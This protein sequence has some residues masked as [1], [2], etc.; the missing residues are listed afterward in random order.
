MGDWDLSM[1]PHSCVAGMVPT[2]PSFR[3]CET[4]FLSLG[5]VSRAIPL[6]EISNI[7]VEADLTSV[8]HR[9]S[10]MEEKKT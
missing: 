1:G 6:C 2:E 3:P 8:Q 10:H 4:H 9:A 5:L 7:C